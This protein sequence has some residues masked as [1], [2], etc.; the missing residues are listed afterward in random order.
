MNLIRRLFRV[1]DRRR[2]ARA[3]EARS[4]YRYGVDVLFAGWVDPPP[5]AREAR[6]RRT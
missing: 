4:R 1:F 3:P 6:S 2:G 5:A